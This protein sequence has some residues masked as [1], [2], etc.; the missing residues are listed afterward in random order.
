MN[1][2][3]NLVIVGLTAFGLVNC[4]SVKNTKTTP[5]AASRY[6]AKELNAG[7]PSVGATSVEGHVLSPRRAESFFSLG[8]ARDA[9][10][11]MFSRQVF[12]KRLAQGQEYPY[13]GYIKV[14]DWP[15][16]GRVYYLVLQHI[17]WSRGSK[18]KGWQ[19]PNPP[20][21][22]RTAPILWETVYGPNDVIDPI[23]RNLLGSG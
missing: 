1:K 3:I 17:N 14:Y 2:L 20:S 13:T 11:L 16:K 22:Y 6:S 21:G 15:W 7:R 12:Y 18:T 10:Q 9:E 8:P 4:Q 5:G 19:G 23:H